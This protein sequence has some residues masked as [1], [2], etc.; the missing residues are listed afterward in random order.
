MTNEWLLFLVGISLSGVAGWLIA[1]SWARSKRSKARDD[2]EKEL[3][4]AG[5]KRIVAQTELELAKSRLEE[6]P[7]LQKEVTAESEARVVAETKLEEVKINLEEQRQLLEEAKSKLTDAFGALAG[8]A[9]KSNNQA[10]LDLAKGTFETIQTEAKSDIEGRQ[11]AIDNLVEPLK[12]SLQRYEKQIQ[13]META[14][15]SAYGSVT[16]HLRALAEASRQLQMETGSLV[17][18][19]RTPQVL[20]RWGEM[21]LR[22]VAELS[23][24]SEHCDFTEQVTAEDESG[25]IRPDMIVNLPAGRQIVVDAKVPLR[26][27]LDAASAKTETERKEYMGRHAQLVRQHMKDLGTRNYWNQFDQAPEFVVLFL[28]GESFFSVALEQDRT[29]IEDGIA[30]G[31]ILATPTTFIAL[32]RA[33]AYGWR[34]ERLAQNAQAISKLGKQLYDRMGTFL[35]HFRGV[36]TNLSRAVT[37]YNQAVGSVESRVLTS[38]R[39]FKELGAA[40]GDELATVETVDETA[41]ELTATEAT[42][43]DDS[44][45]I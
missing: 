31:V 36:G 21:T 5:E 44:E 17:T 20:G 30:K 22:R 13:E 32:V 7:A 18:A 10:F 9:L 29:L 8:E 2:F 43:T 4:E 12:D 24:M 19:L 15:Q 35:N 41:R 14:R 23:G 34:Q 40:T 45:G 42:A 11:K 33:V 38:V 26:A 3:R 28:P 27:F 37:S 1:D 16:E 39:R 6:I 25:R